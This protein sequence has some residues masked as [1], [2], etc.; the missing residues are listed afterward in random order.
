MFPA[1]QPSRVKIRTTAGKEYS[2]YLEFPKGDPREPMTED[3]LK[4]KFNALSADLLKPDRQEKVRKAI[5]SC[6]TMSTRAF[7][8]ELVV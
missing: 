6:E 2:A 3:D 1:K 5:F 4:A 8:T 7:M